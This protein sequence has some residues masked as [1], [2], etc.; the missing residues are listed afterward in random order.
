MMEIFYLIWSG[1]RGG[2]RTIEYVGETSG[3]K[4]FKAK[5]QNELAQD[6]F[7]PVL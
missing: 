6:I 1:G 2:N 5:K 4:N 3:K 7:Q